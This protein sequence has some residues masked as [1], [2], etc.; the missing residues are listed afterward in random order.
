[1][2]GFK[3]PN[4][5]V[6][7]N[8]ASCWGINN[9]LTGAQINK[10][11]NTL[12]EIIEEFETVALD[13]VCKQSEGEWI[14]V[15]DRLP[16]ESGKYIVCTNGKNPYQC[17]F[18]TYPENKGGHWGQKDNGKNITHWMPFPEPPKTKGGEQE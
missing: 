6:V 14:S 1:M 11:E 9:T 15:E 12:A 4:V 5:A 8:G 3:S 18:Y 17:K 13:K 10:L 2:R 7:I 16:R